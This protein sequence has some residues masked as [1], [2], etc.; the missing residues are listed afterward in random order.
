MTARI[1]RKQRRAKRERTRQREEAMLRDTLT[2][3]THTHTHI[4]TADTHKLIQAVQQIGGRAL[5]L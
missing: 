4:P 3:T 1:G 2:R 5:L